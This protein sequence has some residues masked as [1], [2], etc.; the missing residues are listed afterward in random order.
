MGNETLEVDNLQLYPSSFKF[1]NFVAKVGE[2]RISCRIIKMEDSLYLWVG[3]TN[4]S[5]MSDLTVAMIS[6]YESS[7]VATKIIGTNEDSTS[8]SMAKR[9]AKKC[10]R[11]VYVSFNLDVSHVN[12]LL[13]AIEKEI[14][15]E[16]NNHKDLITFSRTDIV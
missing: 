14:Q 10:G 6:R 11:P 4:D 1:H 9:L 13:P 3:E 8:S 2:V 7:P 5:K 12:R 15:T 16:L